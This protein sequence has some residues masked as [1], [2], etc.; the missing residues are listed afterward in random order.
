MK[1]LTPSLAAILAVAAVAFLT[2]TPASASSV[3]LSCTAASLST[4]LAA[5]FGCTEGDLLYTNFTDTNTANPA[6]YALTSSSIAVVPDFTSL[7][8]G[9]EFNMGSSVV[10]QAGA[11]SAFQDE[12]IGYQISTLSGLATI[13]A[14]Q[15]N[16]N[17][18]F[19]GTGSTN[20]TENYCESG[21]VAT[22]TAGMGGSVSVTN[23]PPVFNSVV[24]ITPT[25]TLW[26]IKDANATSG[27]NG[28]AYMSGFGNNYAQTP[29]P[30]TFGMIG[31]S[32]VGLAFVRRRHLQRK[33]Q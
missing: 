6:G 9:F 11:T 2:P 13:Y 27:V 16:F 31:L 7:D 15:V 1:N 17:G 5:G 12:K 14:I 19:T 32:L 21:P 26:V 30:A 29:E 10:T 3:Y 33:E 22:C 24:A 23:P 8:G 25:S 20:M 28:T 4:Y 18:S